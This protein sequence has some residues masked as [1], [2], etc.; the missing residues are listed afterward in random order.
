MTRNHR[1]KNYKHNDEVD[2]DI[3][4]GLVDGDIPH[5]NATTAERQLAV[6][7]LYGEGFSDLYLSQQTGIS[8]TSVQRM[9]S[10]MGLPANYGRGRPKE[11]D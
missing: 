9:R 7:R 1:P 8:K 2:L 5:T 10:I 3:V 4:R 6:K 11:G